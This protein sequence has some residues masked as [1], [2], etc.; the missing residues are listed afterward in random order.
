MNIRSA[1]ILEGSKFTIRDVPIGGKAKRALD[2]SASAAALVFLFPLFAFV[3]FMIKMLD[4]G[5]V[6]FAH[7]RVGYN[8]KLFWCYKFRTMKEDG[9]EMLSAYF[10]SNPE[11]RLEW[12]I[13][14]KLRYDPRITALGKFLRQ[15]SI[16]ELPQLLNVLKGEMS[17]VGP[18]PVTQRE[19]EDKYGSSAGSYLLARPGITGLWQVGGRNDVSYDERVKLDCLYLTTWSFWLDLVILIRT[20]VV[21]VKRDGSY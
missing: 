14:Q 1:N 11:C 12:E 16:D 8:G 6:F 9:D 20:V 3:I 19:L 10:I 7:Q 5:K 2:I 4:G 18:R 13:H 15:T 21:V 17:L